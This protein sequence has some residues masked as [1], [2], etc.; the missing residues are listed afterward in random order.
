M[1]PNLIWFRSSRLNSLG[2]YSHFQMIASQSCLPVALYDWLPPSNSFEYLYWFF[3]LLF[4]W[5]SQFSQTGCFNP[6]II[7]TVGDVIMG[8]TVADILLVWSHL[9]EDNLSIMHWFVGDWGT[10]IA[11]ITKISRRFRSSMTERSGGRA[12]S[13]SLDSGYRVI[14]WDLTHEL[15]KN[16]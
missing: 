10:S 9:I 16:L 8:R 7:N 4:V 1:G 3:S 13:Q 14:Q 5:F 2:N 11:L 6:T 12:C 15:E